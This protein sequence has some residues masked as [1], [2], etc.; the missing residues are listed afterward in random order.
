VSRL[1]RTGPAATLD[2]HEKCCAQNSDGLA[3]NSHSAPWAGTMRLRLSRGPIGGKRVLLRD[4]CACDAACGTCT[5]VAGRDATRT[6]LKLRRGGCHTVCAAPQPR[7]GPADRLWP[8]CTAIASARTPFAKKNTLAR[9]HTRTAWPPASLRP[10]A[11]HDPWR[12]SLS[13]ANPSAN[14]TAAPPAPNT[15]GRL[16]VRP[17]R[18]RGLCFLSPRPCTGTTVTKHLF[19]REHHQNTVPSARLCLPLTLSTGPRTSLREGAADNYCPTRGRAAQVPPCALLF[20]SFV[21]RILKSCVC[22]VQGCLPWSGRCRRFTGLMRTH[23]R[24]AR[25]AFRRPGTPSAIRTLCRE[26][27]RCMVCA[28]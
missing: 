8:G 9:T 26:T 13:P 4:R 23:M 7:E 15:I 3:T 14:P 18:G 6:R 12:S 24:L 16:S 21:V 25:I 17:G 2:A 11:S 10:E 28:S 1:W 20:Y 22:T 5:A 19:F 27:I